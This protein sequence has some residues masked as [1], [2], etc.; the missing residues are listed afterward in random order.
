MSDQQRGAYT[1]THDVPLEFD[2]RSPAARR[3]L[4]LAL[5]ASAGLLLVLIAAVVLVYSRGVRGEN[6]P[7]RPVGEPIAQIKSAPAAAAQPQDASG[8]VDV[9]VPQNTPSRAPSFAPPPEAPKPRAAL[10]ND[11]RLKVVVAP[12]ADAA[13]HLPPPPPPPVATAY[14]STR[15]QGGVAAVAETPPPVAAAPAAAAAPASPKTLAPKLAAAAAPSAAA[16][17]KPASAAVAPKGAAGAS[18]VQIGAFS[19]AALA[20]KGWADVAS[21]LPGS[22]SGKGKV[23]EKVE[24]DGHVLYR[25]SVTGFA[26]RHAADGFCSALKAKG[27]ICLVKS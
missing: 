24:K 15:G 2:P 5:I 16:T 20:E 18:R 22:M 13:A 21:L 23:V 8:D 7:P 6:E 9:S 27:K 4:P 26:D 10:A 25:A 3:P 1:P 14:P 11:A 12:P 19:S 17:A